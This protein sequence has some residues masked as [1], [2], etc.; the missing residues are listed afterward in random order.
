[1]SK[2]EE[3][4]ESRFSREAFDP[5]QLREGAKINWWDR[6]VSRSRIWVPHP[7]DLRSC[8]SWRF[9]QQGW[10]EA[11]DCGAATLALYKPRFATPPLG[12]LSVLCT[13]ESPRVC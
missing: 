6:W 4:Q 12:A 7:N 3:W 10:P 1:M 5:A 2:S 8:A 11:Q 13:F 9:A